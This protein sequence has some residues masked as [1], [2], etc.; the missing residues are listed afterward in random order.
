MNAPLTLGFI[1]FGHMAQAIAQHLIIGSKYRLLAASPRLPVGLSPQG[2]QT[3]ADNVV[4]AQQCDLLILAVKPNQA[5]AVLKQIGHVLPPHAVLISIVAG[6]TRAS[7]A[8]HC[9]ND[10]AIIR[11]MP[12]LPAVIGQGAT[13]LMANAFVSTQQKQQAQELFERIG[14]LHWIEQE[15]DMDLLTALSGSGPAYLFYFLDAIIRAGTQLGLDEETVKSFVLQTMAGS[16][17]LAKSSEAELP[18]L[19]QQVTSPGG[20]TAAALAVFQKNGLDTIIREAIQAALDRSKQLG[21]PEHK[22]CK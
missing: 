2:I 17:Q 15:Q 9:R 10:Q 4:V 20:T 14:I 21:Q 1:G 3:H 6:L 5:I 7:I 16:I 19:I 18:T 12:N 13:P 22:P 8:A 11:S